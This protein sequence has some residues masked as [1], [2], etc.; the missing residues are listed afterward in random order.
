MMSMLKDLEMK[1]SKQQ[2]RRESTKECIFLNE[3]VYARNQRTLY[4]TQTT[5][6]TRAFHPSPAVFGI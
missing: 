1:Q 4:T 2:K 3:E 5:N 6:F